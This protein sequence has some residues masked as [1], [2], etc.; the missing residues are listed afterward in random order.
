V[1]DKIGTFTI[2][3]DYPPPSGSSLAA[4]FR[5]VGNGNPVQFMV[6]GIQCPLPRQIQR[7]I[8]MY[9]AFFLSAETIVEVAMPFHE[10]DNLPEINFSGFFCQHVPAF[11]APDACNKLG[12][13]KQVN[14]L[15][16]VFQ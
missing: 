10:P 14:K 15:F 3:A 5:Q 9:F 7:A 6:K 1:P 16:Q 8:I 11:G 4:F 13:F 2:T 12:L